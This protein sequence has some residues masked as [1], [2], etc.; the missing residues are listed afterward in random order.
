[1]LALLAAFIQLK[2][3]MQTSSLKAEFDN[4]FASMSQYT[5]FLI[6]IIKTTKIEIPP[7]EKREILPKLLPA[8]KKQIHEAFVLKICATW[9]ILAENV[10]VECLL[11]DTSKYKERQ[12]ITLPR[13]K[14]TT[15]I[16]KGL[17]SGLRYFDCGNISS[18]K[19]KARKFLVERCNPFKKVPRD[20]SRKINEFYLIRNYI[21]HRSDASKQSLK[22]MYRQTYKMRFR[23]PGDFFFDTVEFIEFGERGKEIRFANYSKA[24]E[25]A[26]DEMATFLKIR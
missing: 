24:F 15:N 4:F 22:R 21:A 26:A 17:I 13:R 20:V 16:C 23:K 6:K 19:G 9:E 2:D 25:K 3:N 1:M 12:G 18:L 5:D 11:R 14:L 7:Q 10:F 8:E